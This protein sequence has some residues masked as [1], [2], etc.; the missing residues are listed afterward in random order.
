[1]IHCRDRIKEC[2]NVGYSEVILKAEV[3]Q[4][5]FACDIKLYIASAEQLGYV[6]NMWCAHTGTSLRD[7]N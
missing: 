3:P 1:M 7:N 6:T 5:I 2:Y 4:Y